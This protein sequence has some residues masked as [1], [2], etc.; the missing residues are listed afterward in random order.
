MQGLRQQR[1]QVACPL[2]SLKGMYAGVEVLTLLYSGLMLLICLVTV[3]WSG[4]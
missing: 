4:Q 2:E 3:S 1:V